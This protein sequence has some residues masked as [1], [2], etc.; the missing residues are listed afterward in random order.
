VGAFREPPKPRTAAASTGKYASTT[1]QKAR[2]GVSGSGALLA[3]GV[4]A[5]RKNERRQGHN[6]GSKHVDEALG[7]GIGAGAVDAAMTSGGAQAKHTLTRRRESSMSRMNW[8]QKQAHNARWQSHLESHG[9]KRLEG[10]SNATKIKVMSSYPKGLPGWRAQR[11]LAFK[12]RPTVVAGALLT[13]A[14][15]GARAAHGKVEKS[16]GR[17]EE[18]W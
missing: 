14:A 3:A 17:G 7:A 2:A 11:A 16:F 10:A 15:V 6:P 12:N 18:R 13:G 5:S 1:S 8:D 4:L 9:V